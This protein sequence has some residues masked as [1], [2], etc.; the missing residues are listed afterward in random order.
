[1]VIY[2]T[3]GLFFMIRKTS[4]DFRRLSYSLQDI[5]V[6]TLPQFSMSKKGEKRPETR[7]TDQF[8]KNIY[9]ENYYDV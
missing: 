3:V 1:M 6:Q 7:S 2:M 4:E 5:H 8:S 9:L